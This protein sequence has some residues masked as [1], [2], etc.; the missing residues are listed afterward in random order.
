MPG[1]PRQDRAG[2]AFGIVV[3]LDKIH[4]GYCLRPP[5]RQKPPRLLPFRK[6]FTAITLTAPFCNPVESWCPD[7]AIATLYEQST[8]G[9]EP[10]NLNQHEGHEAHEGA[11]SPFFE[12]FV[13]FVVKFIAGSVRA[14]RVVLAFRI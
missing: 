2:A 8:E 1:T 5:P 12:S 7:A 4:W 3:G 11:R 6:L 9:V 13:L 10:A 14:F